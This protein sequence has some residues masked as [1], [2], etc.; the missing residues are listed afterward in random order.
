MKNL[1]VLLSKSTTNLFK[2]SEYP[3][4]NEATLKAQKELAEVKNT[5]FNDVYY[6]LF[7]K[8]IYPVKVFVDHGIIPFLIECIQ[9]QND[10]HGLRTDA[11]CTLSTIVSDSSEYCQMIIDCGG[12]P[13]LVKLFEDSNEIVRSEAYCILQNILRFHPS[14]FDEC[15]ELNF[16]D[17]IFFALSSNPSSYEWMSLSE[18]IGVCRPDK[19]ILKN[20][21]KF[22]FSLEK[23]FPTKK[24]ITEEIAENSW[25]L[26]YFPTKKHFAEQI[27]ETLWNLCYE[28]K[29]LCQMV[30]NCGILD[31]LVPLWNILREESSTNIIS[32]FGRIAR[33]KKF[34]TIIIET[35]VLKIIN[36]LLQSFDSELIEETL[37]F[38]FYFAT[39]P[40]SV[41]EIIEANI[42]PSLIQISEGC[43]SFGKKAALTL[44][45]LLYEGNSEQSMKIIKMNALPSLYNYLNNKNDEILIQRILE[46][47]FNVLKKCEKVSVKLIYDEMEECGIPDKI[48]MLQSHENVEIRQLSIKFVETYFKANIASKSM[49]KENDYEF[50]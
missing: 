15:M 13:I 46:T 14:I 22:L 31:K 8:K 3:L 47:F 17:K 48:K 45:Q 34:N 37:S 5:I 21:E 40:E 33:Q 1:N 39:D 11:A 7:V 24:E 12:I 41:Q 49:K 30:I 16:H 42:I 10:I 43:G 20:V 6:L 50:V 2:F 23:Y 26:F 38:L 18:L 36:H 25:N 44:Q 9:I 32:A 4:L 19:N 35:G 28:E 27:T 29:E